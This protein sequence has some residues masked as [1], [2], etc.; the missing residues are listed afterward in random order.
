MNMGEINR[1]ILLVRPRQPYLDWAASLPNPTPVTLEDLR[2][3][4]NAYLVAEILDPGDELAV[5]QNH[6]AAIFEHELAGWVTEEDLW[7]GTRTLSMFTAWFDVEFHGMV[8]DLCGDA[9]LHLDTD[10]G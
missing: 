3:D 1:S 9:V 4:C 5:L 6:Y 2:E 8:F 10:D 7:P